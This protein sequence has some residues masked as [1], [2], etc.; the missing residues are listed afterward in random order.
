MGSLR[1]AHGKSI[2]GIALGSVLPLCPSMWPSEGA[3]PETPLSA[4]SL[5][6]CY[7]GYVTS[8]FGP[9]FSSVNYPRRTIHVKLS[10]A[11][12]FY[13]FPRGSFLLLETQQFNSNPSTF[14]VL[15]TFSDLSSLALTKSCKGANYPYFIV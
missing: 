8:C 12:N 1:A 5:N 4:L 9:V 7:R 2:S 14:G 13:D 11:L 6:S 3:H 15:S 10:P